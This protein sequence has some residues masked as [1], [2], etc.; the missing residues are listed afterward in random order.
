[1]AGIVFL[2]TKNL[3]R[4]LAFYTGPVGM[5]VWLE[6]PEITILRHENLLIGFQQDS[7]PDTGGLITFF[8]PHKGDVDAMFEALGSVALEPPRINERYRIYQFF[9]R[10][11][12]GRMVEFQ[13]FLH[14]LPAWS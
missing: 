1:M 8:F 13:Q 5:S 7:A 3:A 4:I 2:K 9:A 14:D 12:D 6:Q 11:P 10:D